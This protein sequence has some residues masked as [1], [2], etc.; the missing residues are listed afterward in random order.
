LQQ[1]SCLYCELLESQLMNDQQVAT[2]A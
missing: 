2:V 1:T